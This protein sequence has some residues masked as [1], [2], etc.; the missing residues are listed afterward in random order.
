MS[1][2][3]LGKERDTFH[4]VFGHKEASSAKVQHCLGSWALQFILRSAIYLSQPSFFFSYPRNK[5]RSHRGSQ[6][7]IYHLMST[8]GPQMRSYLATCI[9][10]VG[11]DVIKKEE[12]VCISHPEEHTPPTVVTSCTACGGDKAFKITTRTESLHGK[13]RNQ[14]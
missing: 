11:L 8:R 9:Y 14:V 10:T 12:L 6:G 1:S 13:T 3:H 7:K 2:W 5:V 4:L